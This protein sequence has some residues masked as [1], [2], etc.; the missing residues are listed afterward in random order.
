M[1][2][3]GLGEIKKKRKTKK[4]RDIGRGGVKEVEGVEEDSETDNEKGIC[5]HSR[6]ADL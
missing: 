1:T 2:K 6:N 4:H 3:R 5:F